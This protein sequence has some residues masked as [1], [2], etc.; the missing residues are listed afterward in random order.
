MISLNWKLRLD[1][2]LFVFTPIDPTDGEG[3]IVLPELSYPG[4]QGE[5]ILM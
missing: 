2:D 4:F 3:I 1:S 5:N